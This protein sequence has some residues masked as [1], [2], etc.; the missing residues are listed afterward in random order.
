MKSMTT[1]WMMVAAALAIATGAASAQTLKAEIPFAFRAGDKVMTPG[2]Y[3]VRVERHFVILSNYE[4]EQHS[5]LP[6]GV[7][8]DPSKAWVAKGKP[9]MT[10]A[11]AV[12]RCEL[13]SLWPGS[14][15]TAMSY[16]HR[17]LGRDETASVIIPS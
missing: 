14:G 3:T 6:S 15:A 9:V 13:A 12:S 10:F 11:C 17:R 7:P 2:T 5:I 1:K 8:G 16:P 4:T